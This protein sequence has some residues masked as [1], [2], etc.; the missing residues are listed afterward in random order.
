MQI[1]HLME[2]LLQMFFLFALHTGQIWTYFTKIT[3]PFISEKQK[4]TN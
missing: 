1:T 3:L 4:I 2:H